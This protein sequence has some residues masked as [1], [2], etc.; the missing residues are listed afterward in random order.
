MDKKV[1]IA[2]SGG[3]DS[4]AAALL[5]KSQAGTV[6]GATG[7][8]FYNKDI[9]L[10]CT[11][12]E[13]SEINDARAVA[14]AL[15]MP[16]YVFDLTG[17]FKQKVIDYF[18]NAYLQGLTPNPC[19]ACNRHIKFTAFA[20]QAAELGYSHVATGHYAQIEQSGDRFLL[21]KAV[22]TAKDQS[23]VLF[24]LTQK[25]LSHTLL[26]L[27][28]YTKEQ[29]RQ[30]A[31][32]QSL[33]NAK[34]HD[35]QDICFIKDGDYAGFIGRYANYQSIPGH[36]TDRQGNVLGQHKGIIHYTTG[37]RRGLG[38]SLKAPLYVLDKDI[39]NNRVIL[40]SNEDLFTKSLDACDINLIPFDK[41]DGTMRLKAKI[42]Y[43]HT[44]DWAYVTQTAPD[45]LHIE[46]EQPQRAVTRGQAVVLYQDDY[47]VGGGTIL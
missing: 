1:M 28:Q 19:I 45:R 2:M 31:E 14:V 37:Q 36:F 22:D 27:G 43:K 5:V 41:I 16:H 8:M 42:R 13:M 38:L 33:V 11:D 47:V 4:S 24:P 29:I 20:E 40:C 26:P 10:P 21:K 18:I 35:S 44:E 39:E 15:D 12:N 23:Y 7:K 17:K 3:V 32:E 30:M 46:F 25:Q 34:K 6:A 9:G